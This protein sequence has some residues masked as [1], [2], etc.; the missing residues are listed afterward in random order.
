MD[1]R[2]DKQQLGDWGENEAVQFL[3]QKG[4][5]VIERKYRVKHCDLDIIAWNTKRHHG[6]T[7]CFIEVKTR[8]GEWGTAEAATNDKK[9]RNIFHAAKEYCLSHN[10]AVDR[11]PI[12]FEQVSVYVSAH[13]ATPTCKHDVIPVE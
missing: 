10:I 8:R 13:S 9:Q 4:Y 5:E 1:N 7:L 11:I 6:A 3:Q 2:T 12:Q